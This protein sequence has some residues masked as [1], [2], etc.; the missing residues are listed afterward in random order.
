MK[1]LLLS[2]IT[3]VAFI[4]CETTPTDDK[5]Q[6]NVPPTPPVEETGI[7]VSIDNN[8]LTEYQVV[9][10]IRPHDKAAYYY[11]DV[12]SK[13]RFETADI[14]VVKEEF[15]T[16]LRNYAE[17]TGD[18][19]EAV[20]EQMLFMGDTEEFVSNAGYRADTDFV[21][22]TFYWTE[23]DLMPE[24]IYVTEFRTPSHYVS[25]ENVAITF[26]SVDPYEMNVKC[27]PTSNVD[28]YY[29]YFDETAKVEAMLAELEDEN[30]YM[31]YQAMNV[32]TKKSGEQ[33]M[34]QKGLKPETSYTALLM[35]IDKDGHRMQT[36]AAQTTPAQTQSSHIESELFESLLGEWSGTQTITDGFAEP[37]VNTFTVNIVTGVE[38]YDY[39]YRDNNQL[40][41]LVDEWCNIQYWGI[42]ELAQ[43]QGIEEADV[44]WGPKWIFDIAE[45]DVITIDG[46]ARYSVV[47]WQFFGHSYILSGNPATGELALDTT[48]NVTL[49]ED[50]N[51]LTISSPLEGYYPSLGYNFQDISW[52]AQRYGQSDIVLTRK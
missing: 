38:D 26:D 49:S 48:L 43:D 24:D 2:L 4:G 20:C 42:T 3:L 44:K 33:T 40:L 37:T 6:P 45:G 5:K 35:V 46:H 25:P 51:T 23:D 27:V 36:S 28:C 21:I 29:Y 1:K 30:A 19:Y 14:N 12:M 7:V 16:A 39:N 47:G 9:Y 50:G 34:S 18:T 31:S 8:R 15:D 32:G 11:C 13:A 41:A 10:S 22:F 52:M 17:M